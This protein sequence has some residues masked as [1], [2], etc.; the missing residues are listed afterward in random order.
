MRRLS[1]IF[2]PNGSFAPNSLLIG[3]WLAIFTVL[4]LVLMPAIFPTP[5]EVVLALPSLWDDGVGPELLSSWLVN[6]EA[7][8]LSTLIGLPICYLSRTPAI[9]PL[10]TGLAKLRFTGSA[11]FYL[12]LLMVLPSAHSIKVGLLTL[13]ELFYLVT[14][15][16]GV[17]NSIP[18]S[19][20]DDAATLKMSPLKAVWY[21]NI[22]GTIP[23]A[24]DAIKDNAG[25]GWSMLMFVEGLVRSEGGIGVVLF[26]SEKHTSY[27]NFFAAVLLVIIVGVGQDWFLRTV[28]KAV[29]PYA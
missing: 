27:D 11:V 6:F 1:S 9:V 12:P 16:S 25:V 19:R 8:I 24:I 10:S 15:M 20:Y 5:L 7:L 14:T 26:N 21:V 29:C 2:T 17:I 4:W 13:G 3:A 22:R 18:E 28:R 23:A